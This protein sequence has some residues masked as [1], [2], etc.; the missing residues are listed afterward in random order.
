MADKK[1]DKALYGPSVTEVALGAVL[2][3]LV[4]V[5]A[6][7]VYLVY[8]PVAQVKALPKEPSRSVMYYIPGSESSSKTRNWQAKQKLFLAGTSI[9]VVEDE[10]NA[11][12]LSA[13]APAPAA[14]KPG[15]KPAPAAKADEAKPAPAGLIIPYAPN[16]KVVDDKLQIGL[17]CTLNWYGLTYDTTVVATG[18]FG[19]SGDQVVFVPEKLYLGS[20]PLHLLPV[21]PG[22]IASQVIAREKVPDEI[23]TAWTKLTA[24]TI[25]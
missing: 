24:V 25:E 15:A 18:G 17:K 10:L 13:S 9:S 19:K 4:G 6:A 7:A 5:L 14:P 8:K 20:C 3:L 22:L 12:A 11:W 23:R 1:I 2:G 21:L 16:F